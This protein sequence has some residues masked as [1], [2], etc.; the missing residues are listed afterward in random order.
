MINIRSSALDVGIKTFKTSKKATYSAQT[1][2][3][4]SQGDSE[5]LQP[6]SRRCLANDQAVKRNMLMTSM[7]AAAVPTAMT[8]S[9]IMGS[10][11]AVWINTA[12]L[13][14]FS[15]PRNGCAREV[16]GSRGGLIS[17][18]RQPA[19]GSARSIARRLGLACL[20]ESS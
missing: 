17:R 3:N 20:R 9:E 18:G 2:L 7:P 4:G 1:P 8:P 11:D 5:G 16:V 13:L 14:G 6:G 12:G 10:M 15:T 19:A